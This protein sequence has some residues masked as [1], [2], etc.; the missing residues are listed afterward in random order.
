MLNPRRER[1]RASAYRIPTDRPE[2]DGTLRW[3]AT[4]M[5]VV[6][7]GADGQSGLGYTYADAGAA[8][9]VGDVLAAAV[10][11]RDAM[12]IRGAWNRM[13]RAVRNIGLSGAAASAVAAVAVALWDLKAR[14]LDVSVLT[15]L[16]AVREGV[17]VYGSGVHV[18]SRD[19]A[20]G[21]ARRLG[22]GRHPAGE[23]EG[24]QGSRGGPRTRPGRPP[25]DRRQRRAAGGTRT[26]RCA[27]GTPRLS[28]SAIPTCRAG[29]PGI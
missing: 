20:A 8:R 18:L 19:G 28:A 16:G 12:D 3:D 24:R 22:R 9:L 4:T 2:S 29:C 26:A 10:T 13:V 25:G 11:G 23:D 21:P 15:L 14:L 1:L 27:T 5:V 17:D 6:E 7:A